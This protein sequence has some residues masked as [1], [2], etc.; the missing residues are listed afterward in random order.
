MVAHGVA[1]ARHW[2]WAAEEQERHLRQRQCIGKRER[3][4]TVEIEVDH[5]AI[6]LLC[7]HRGQRRGDGSEWA[8]H[9]AA[10]ITDGALDIHR[11]EGIVLDH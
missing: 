4:M 3:W 5:G 1:G 8:D 6:R 2:R 7:P 11:D 9:M 10:E